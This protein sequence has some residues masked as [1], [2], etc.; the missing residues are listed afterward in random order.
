MIGRLAEEMRQRGM[1]GRREEWRSEGR[2]ATEER[3]VG[4]GETRGDTLG[5]KAVQREVLT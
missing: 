3:V 4:Q 5:G 1:H 2:C